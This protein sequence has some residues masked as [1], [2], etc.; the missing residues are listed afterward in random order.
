MEPPAVETTSQDPYSAIYTM[1]TVTS[2][3]ECIK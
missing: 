3:P 2:E 1:D